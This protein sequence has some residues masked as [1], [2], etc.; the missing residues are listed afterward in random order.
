MIERQSQF[1]DRKQSPTRQCRWNGGGGFS[2]VELVIVIVI[3]AVIAAIAVP[4]INTA[5]E[6]AERVALRARLRTVRDAIDRYYVDHRNIYPGVRTDGVN[7]AGSKEAFKN[8]LLLYS[9]IK[10][11]VSEKL[12]P[13]YPFGPYIRGEFPALPTG[14]NE[15]SDDVSIVSSAD[16]IEADTSE[17]TGWVYNAGT[18]E[19]IANSDETT[20]DGVRLDKF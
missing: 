1:K 6:K 11:V 16:A 5:G 19:F 9:N 8:Q 15:G 18:G 3:L 14:D 12:D 17:D 20:E 7:P 2:L 4:R 10:G 13:A